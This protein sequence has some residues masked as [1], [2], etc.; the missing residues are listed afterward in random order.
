MNIFSKF[1]GYNRTSSKAN[2]SPKSIISSR[3]KKAALPLAAQL[4]KFITDVEVISF[5]EDEKVRVKPVTEAYQNNRVEFPSQLRKLLP[6]GTSFMITAK[7][8]Q[9]HNKDGSKRGKI[10]LKAYD[11]KIVLPSEENLPNLEAALK[12]PKVS[13]IL[14]H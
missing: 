10:Y 2:E 4:G 8:C 12:Q 13:G 1:F 3:K 9:K 14:K 5:C 11:I 6:V 7:V